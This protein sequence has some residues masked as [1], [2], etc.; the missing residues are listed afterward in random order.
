VIYNLY[1]STEIAYATIATPEDLE[2]DPS[3]VGKVVRGSVVKL[4]DDDGKREIEPGETGRIFVGNL[5]QF[6]GY[7][8]GGNK[9]MVNG[10]M[11]SGDVGHFD[12]DGRLFIDG[13][14]DEMIVSGGENVFPAEVEE[15]LTSH[16]SVQEAAAI[17]VQD[18]KFGQRLKA[19][20]V[21]CDGAKLSEDELKAHVKDNLANYKVPR[22]VVFLDELPRNQTGKVLKR[23][24]EER[25]GDG[26]TRTD[27]GATN[28]KDDDGN[29]AGTKR[30][31]TPRSKPEAETAK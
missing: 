5:S 12:D 3:T 31:R 4:Y 7:T 22:E 13:R 1:G 8:G 14:D 29:A 26:E 28:G 24:L 17:G 16:E 25:E 9:D 2:A 20:V 23:D 21:L 6:E 27:S 18:E 11:A 15:C 10:L 19:F 30:T